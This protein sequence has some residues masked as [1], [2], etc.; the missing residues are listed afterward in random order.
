MLFDDVENTTQKLVIDSSGI[1]ITTQAGA[2]TTLRDGKVVIGPLSP[3]CPLMVTRSDNNTTISL[4]EA[5]FAVL[6]AYE[7]NPFG[8]IIGVNKNTGRPWLQGGN[9]LGG[10][11]PI[12]L[13]PSGN[14]VG[15]GTSSP[16]FPLHVMGGPQ[17]ALSYPA[18]NTTYFYIGGWAGQN[19]SSSS[20]ATWNPVQSQYKHNV[21][22][23]SEKSIAASAYVTPSDTRI[24]TDIS[25]V[26]DKDALDKVNIIESKEY[27]YLDPSKRDTIKTVGFIAQQI[28][29]VLPN[30]IA[31]IKDYI[32][33]EL[34]VI[35]NLEWNMLEDKYSITI[36]D[37][38]LSSNNTGKC[39]FYVSNDPSGN[40]EVM[41]EVTVEPDNKTFVFDDSWNNV[42]FYGKEVNDFHTVD[43]Q[44]IFQLHHPAIQQLS[45][46]NDEKT[47]QIA[48]MQ[49]KIANL[50]ARLLALE[51]K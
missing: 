29:E 10:T 21:S 44:K 4:Q 13:Q 42:F 12:I 45:R 7:P 39:R 46:L 2:L 27:N 35:D 49:D 48:T 8:L 25:S 23:Y 34:R 18:S 5:K 28:K 32:P 51:S 3:I 41:R 50:E 31:I 36:P 43:K 15:I 37:L 16:D 47:E 19:Q 9:K 20:N 26:S 38:D 14:N 6:E 11:Y 1:D 22:I 17:M 24:K 33:D 40:D 30:A